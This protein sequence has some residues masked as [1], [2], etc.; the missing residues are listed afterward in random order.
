MV[1]APPTEQAVP[2]PTGSAASSQAPS[3]WPSG[4]PRYRRGHRGSPPPWWH[5]H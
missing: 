2:R 3:W 1:G 4:D 5:H